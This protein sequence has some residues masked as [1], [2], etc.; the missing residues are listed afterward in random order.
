MRRSEN[1]NIR[2]ACC[3]N[4]YKYCIADAQ[5]GMEAGGGVIWK[6]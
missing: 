2:T 5:A 6:L 4:I 1:P 3:L